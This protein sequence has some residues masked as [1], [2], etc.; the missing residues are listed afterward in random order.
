M[1]CM[2]PVMDGYKTTQKI[3]ELEE[4]QNLN[5]TPI[6]ALTADITS[7]NKQKCLDAGMNEYITKPF[8]FEE[9]SDVL[10]H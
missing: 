3:R 2:M 1:D 9:L 4:T 6:V 10:K 8:N 5:P 7:E